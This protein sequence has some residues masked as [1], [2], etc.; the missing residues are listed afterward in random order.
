MIRSVTDPAFLRWGVP[1]SAEGLCAAEDGVMAL[2][3]AGEVALLRFPQDTVWAHASGMAVLLI[4][5]E[6]ALNAMVAEKIT[7]IAAKRI[8]TTV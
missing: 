1:V 4:A 6:G 5:E 2:S 8:E 7:L 3:P